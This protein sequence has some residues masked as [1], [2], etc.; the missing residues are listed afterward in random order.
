[1]TCFEA[2]T[3]RW[4]IVMPIALRTEMDKLLSAARASL[5]HHLLPSAVGPN[6]YVAL[7]FAFV[8]HINC[9][10]RGLLPYWKRTVALRRPCASS[11]EPWRLVPILS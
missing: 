7:H 6:R 1:M 3:G 8:G 9:W 5:Y 4:A 10:L 11:C 2:A